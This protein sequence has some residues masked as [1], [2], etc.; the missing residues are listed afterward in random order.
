MEFTYHCQVHA[1]NRLNKIYKIPQNAIISNKYLYGLEN[2]EFVDTFSELQDIAVSVYKDMI[3]DSEGYGLKL[4]PAY[5]DGA[6][7]LVSC[8][9][10]ILYAIGSL[11]HLQNDEILVDIELY[12]KKVQKHKFYKVQ[13]NFR[14]LVLYLKDLTANLL[15]RI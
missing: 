8:F 3:N 4:T 6:V 11:G 1:N 15:I 10:N 5:K 13:K 9:G 14:T 7:N 12:K 2:T